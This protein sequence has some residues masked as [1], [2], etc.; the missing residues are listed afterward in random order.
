MND[1]N[2][3]APAGTLT[4]EPFGVAVPVAAG[5]RL[6]DAILRAGHW[7]PFGCNHGGCGTCAA[8]VVA[9]QVHQQPDTLTT[10]DSR[11]RA[12]GQILLCSTRLSGDTAAIDITA[13]GL[14]E[15]EFRSTTIHDVTTTIRT[16]AEVGDGLRL[17][18]LATPPPPWQLEPGQFLHLQL[19]DLT[20]WRAYSPASPPGT[21]TMDLLIRT[22]PGG[23]FST[24]L[25]ELAPGDTIRCRGPFG[26]FTVR[27]SHRHK[28]FIGGGAGIGPLRAMIHDALGRRLHTPVDLIHTARTPA[29]LAFGDEFTAL[30]AT[31]DR[32]HYHP[33]TPRA[34]GEATRGADLVG[35][36]IDTTTIPLR[37]AEAYL[38]G[39]DRFVDIVAD[40]LVRAGLRPRYLFT[41]RFTASTGGPTDNLTPSEEP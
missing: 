20:G 19:P 23:A 36:W 26:T 2:P 31:D 9:G 16:V 12:H 4:V 5:E 15:E 24:A 10:L 27:S 29:D 21:A 22:V 14:T 11:A 35:G 33:L 6:L 37:R 18:R 28:L 39:P 41:D 13:G 30:A 25:D 34:Q 8:R 40:R 17:L 32:F 38:C 3:T 1:P 7:V